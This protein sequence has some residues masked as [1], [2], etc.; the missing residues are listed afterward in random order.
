MSNGSAAYANMRK[1]LLNMIEEIPK[2]YVVEFATIAAALN[3]PSRHVAYIISQLK[4][5][6]LE[7]LAWHRVIPKSGDFGP[8]QKMTEKKLQQISK[9]HSEGAEFTGDRHIDFNTVNMWGPGDRFK[10]AFWAD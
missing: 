3:I 5:E 8:K 1:A 4:S 10:D 6:E 7:L 2:G 9:L